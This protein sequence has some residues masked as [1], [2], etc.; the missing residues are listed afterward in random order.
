M[1]MLQRRPKIFWLTTLIVF[2]TIATVTGCASAPSAPQ[3]S[4]KI[5]SN[6]DHLIVP[7]QRIG[8]V[9]LGMSVQQLIATLGTPVK[10]EP[11]GGGNRSNNSFSI[12]LDVDVSGT[13]VD[14][15]FA[16]NSTYKT[17]EGVGLGMSD[18]EVRALLGA[19][20]K[21]ALYGGY[22]FRTCYKSGLHLMFGRSSDTQSMSLTSILVSAPGC[23]V[24]P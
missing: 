16:R 6:N 10:S 2:V 4:A 14:G 11:Y 23:K 19:P 17:A 3:S 12:G 5:P 7:G 1:T 15:I 20:D 24:F 21:H 9:S 22:D 18:L 8:Q 13:A